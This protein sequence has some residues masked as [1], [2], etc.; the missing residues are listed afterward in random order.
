MDDA[1]RLHARL[2]VAGV[3]EPSTLA[4]EFRGPWREDDPAPWP[5]TALS[6][7]VSVPAIRSARHH[8]GGLSEGYVTYEILH[9]PRAARGA[10]AAMSFLERATLGL[11]D[12]VDAIRAGGVPVRR[13]VA[14]GFTTPCGSLERDVLQTL[15]DVLGERLLA[16]PCRD[17]AQVG[18]ALLQ[19]LAAHADD[20]PS[21]S[22]ALRALREPGPEFLVRRDLAAARRYKGRGAEPQ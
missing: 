21:F 8:A 16:R 15:A 20:Y 14:T 22:M 17:V 13:F 4:I 12:A 11:R 6:S 19:R 7:R 3:A 10:A 18:A 5:R 2:V 9:A 1:A